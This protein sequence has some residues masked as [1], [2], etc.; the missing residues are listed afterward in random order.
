MNA[1]CTMKISVKPAT[2]W[3][4]Y[5]QKISY[6]VKIYAHLGLLVAHYTHWTI[7][8]NHLNQF[9]LGDPKTQNIFHQKQIANGI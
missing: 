9:Y 5:E 8:L 6:N 4:Q 7:L 3:E 1:P 2:K